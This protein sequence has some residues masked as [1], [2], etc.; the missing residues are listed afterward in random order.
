MNL[1]CSHCGKP[2][3][4]IVIRIESSVTVLKPEANGL[5]TPYTNFQE[6]TSEMLCLDCFDRY[7][8]CI[9]TLNEEINTSR[10]SN[11]VE[12]IDSIQYG[13]EECCEEC[14][15]DPSDSSETNS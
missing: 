15:E 10:I 2:I 6:P 14:C 11:M 3:K 13:E 12:I 9:N 5:L 4:D 8:Q 1:Y 7:T